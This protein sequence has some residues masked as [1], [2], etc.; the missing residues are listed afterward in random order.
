ME[1]E[2]MD[3]TMDTF[4]IMVRQVDDR[5]YPTGDLAPRARSQLIDSCLLAAVLARGSFQPYGI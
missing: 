4:A 1:P 2:F 5:A 3:R